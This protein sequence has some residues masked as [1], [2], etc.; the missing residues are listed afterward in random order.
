[1][2]EL[3]P[4]RWMISTFAYWSL[5]Y[6]VSA[7]TNQ[8]RGISSPSGGDA[9]GQI[10]NQSVVV[11]RE[12]Q[13]YDTYR[14]PVLVQA[15]NDDLL[16]FCEARG[17]ESDFGNIDIVLFRS[18]DGGNTWN[19]RSV[20]VDNGIDTASDL[21]AVVKG[22]TIHFFYQLRPAGD[23]FNEYL[24]GGAS[25]AMG[26]H[27]YSEDNGKTWSDP[28]DITDQVLL[29]SDEQ[30][31]MFGPNNGI[32]LESGRLLVPMY[33]ADQSA[34]TW[35]PAVIYSDDEGQTWQ[36]SADAIPGEGVG[37]TAVVQVQNGDVYAIARDNSNDADWQK[38]FFR[39]SDGGE[40]WDEAGDVNA[41]ITEIRCQQSMVSSGDR[42]FFLDP[43]EPERRDGRLK[44][45][46]YDLNE[47]DLVDWSSNELQI[48]SE[49]FA[50][51]SMALH[52]STLHVVYEEVAP[53]EAEHGYASLQYARIQ[54]RS[55]LVRNQSVAQ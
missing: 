37:E 47:P 4:L 35:T 36:R 2:K 23:T 27:I 25:E 21:A 34:N 1:M 43:V 49:G 14:I 42:I 16:L 26:Y 10:V 48:T 41:F 55:D 18:Q 44:T 50:Y 52:D 31:P 33:Y 3:A 30:L 19:E 46:L 40:T 5:I 28:V 22:D 24:E 11:E 38:R 53:E 12:T 13:G 7:C 39:S 45:G 15:S 51:S 29:Q 8:P 32:V 17:T 54:L 20:V 9:I 6:L